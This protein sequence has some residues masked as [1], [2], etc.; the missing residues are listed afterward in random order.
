MPIKKTS[1][2]SKST[3]TDLVSEISQTWP[4]FVQIPDIAHK[5]ELAKTYVRQTDD[6]QH[7]LISGWFRE[8]PILQFA[9]IILLSGTILVVLRY[10]SRQC[11]VTGKKKK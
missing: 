4:W 7:R 5:Y 2:P 1:P 8:H 10:W 3:S 6:V 9:A 11:C